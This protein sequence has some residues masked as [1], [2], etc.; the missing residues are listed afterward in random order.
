MFEVL[1]VV[2]AVLINLYILNYL[3]HLEKIGCKCA[4][5]W[6]RKFIMVFIGISL[7]VAVLG[8]FKVDI[9][10]SSLVLTVFA[11][12]SIANIVIILQYIHMLKTEKC[13]CS[14]DL[15]REILQLIAALYAFFYIMLFIVLFYSG[16][17][18]AS[19]VN[20]SKQL[21]SNNPQVMWKVM[22]KSFKNASKSIRNSRK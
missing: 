17:K 7:L 20:L 16:F 5:D 2:V 4:L 9:L 11:G 14:S 18:I 3:H 19:I 6:R 21:A 15:A 13:T 1:F 10:T 8:M 12:L 22:G